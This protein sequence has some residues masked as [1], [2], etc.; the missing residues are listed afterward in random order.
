GNHPSGNH[1]QQRRNRPIFPYQPKRLLS[2]RVTGNALLSS[3]MPEAAF[4]LQCLVFLSQKEENIRLEE[5]SIFTKGT[6]PLK[7]NIKDCGTRPI[8]TEEPGIGFTPLY[9][10]P[11]DTLSHFGGRV[12]LTNPSVVKA[13]V[14]I[15]STMTQIQLSLAKMVEFNCRAFKNTPVNLDFPRT[16]SMSEFI[17][18]SMS[19]G[20]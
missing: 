16:G 11:E 14:H 3:S 19:A 10:V 18:Q 13:P 17:L 5:S 2:S 12:N 15:Q 4:C 6:G 20:C 8:F 9:M 1:P 7:N